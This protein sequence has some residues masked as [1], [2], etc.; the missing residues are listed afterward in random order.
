MLEE[1]NQ[2]EK[3]KEKGGVGQWVMVIF[4]SLTA[5]YRCVQARQIYEASQN[6]PGL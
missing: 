6:L 4:L 2:L 3:E 1:K 5:L